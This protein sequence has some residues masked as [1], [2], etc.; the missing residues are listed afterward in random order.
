MTNYNNYR[1]SRTI[2]TSTQQLLGVLKAD[3]TRYAD[4]ALIALT[5]NGLLYLFLTLTLAGQQVEHI[6]YPAQATTLL[7]YSS[8]YHKGHGMA[9]G[10]HPDFKTTAALTITRFTIRQQGLIRRPDPNGSFQYAIP[11][12]H[13]FGSVD[14]YPKMTYGMRDTLQ[15][16]RKDDN[17]ALVPYCSCGWWESKIV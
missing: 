12:R 14:D 1:E 3:D 11:M 15:T 13:I 16:I 8:D 2:P 5:N 10:W 4:A 6:K 9:Q 7:G 17:D